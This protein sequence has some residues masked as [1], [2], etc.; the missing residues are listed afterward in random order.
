MSLF[1]YDIL[2]ALDTL[3]QFDWLKNDERLIEITEVVK[4]KAN[5]KGKYFPNQKRKPGKVRILD[6]RN[7]RARNNPK[8]PQT[9]NRTGRRD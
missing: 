6:I 9:N 5:L 3:S 7:S 2:N 8:K 1:W 4:L